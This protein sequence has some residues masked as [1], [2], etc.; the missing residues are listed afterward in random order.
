MGNTQIVDSRSCYSCRQVRNYV[1]V[2][3]ENFTQSKAQLLTSIAR[4]VWRNDTKLARTLT[5]HSAA[6]LDFLEVDASSVVLKS[7]SELEQSTHIYI[8]IYIYI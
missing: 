5:K 8:Y 3:D 2:V 6:V 4:A 1:L 7:P